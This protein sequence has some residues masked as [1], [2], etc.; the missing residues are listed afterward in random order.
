MNDMSL[1]KLKPFYDQCAT[2]YGKYRGGSSITKGGMPLPSHF[3]ADYQ[4]PAEKLFRLLRKQNSDWEEYRQDYNTRLLSYVYNSREI[5]IAFCETPTTNGRKKRFEIFFE[6]FL[7][8]PNNGTRKTLPFSKTLTIGETVLELCSKRELEKVDQQYILNVTKRRKPS[9]EKY[10]GSCQNF[11]DI[12]RFPIMHSREESKIH[13]IRAIVY[14]CDMQSAA[15]KAIADFTLF[16]NCLNV[17]LAHSKYNIRIF[18]TNDRLK[19]KLSIEDTGV[20]LV[21]DSN[22]IERFQISDMSKAKPAL[23]YAFSEAQRARFR[24]LLSLCT[25][26]SK[27]KK[28]IQS[29]VEELALAAK[30]DSTATRQLAYWRCLEHAT[31][32]TNGGTRKEAEI[33][34]IFEMLKRD[35]G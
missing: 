22:D 15:E 26:D 28:R 5:D 7:N 34:S 2:A 32:F 33:I 21:K 9:G 25:T 14:A 35:F 23:E 27:M 8:H 12:R 13:T 29:V 11:K 10:F 6:M 19:N 20:Y 31:R 24:R 17:V 30:T 3:D 4:V 16:K 18:S 1:Q